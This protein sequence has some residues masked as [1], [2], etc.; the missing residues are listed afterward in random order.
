VCVC[1][2]G[3][4][5][6]FRSNFLFRNIQYMGM[7]FSDRIEIAPLRGVAPELRNMVFAKFIDNK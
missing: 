6:V 4:G 3:G 5:L 7:C 1:V 2:G